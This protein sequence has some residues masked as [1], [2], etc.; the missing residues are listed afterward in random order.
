MKKCGIE[1]RCTVHVMK[2][3][4]GGG[5]HKNKK[6]TQN[7]QK[8]QS[9]KFHSEKQEGVQCVEWLQEVTRRH[10]KEQETSQDVQDISEQQR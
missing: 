3:L 4:S 7:K 5:N 6:K 8:K 1:A 10:N 9:D 2:R